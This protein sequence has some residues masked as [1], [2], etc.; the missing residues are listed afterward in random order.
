MSEAGAG[1][2]FDETV[3]K[4]AFFDRIVLSI[5][6]QR[7]IPKKSLVESNI[8][9]G[10]KKRAYARSQK[11]NLPSGNPYELK[12]GRSNWK[13][14]LPSLILTLR[15]EAS[16]LTVIETIAALRSL[17]DDVTRAQI[18]EAELTFDLA[19]ISVDYFRQ[20][21]KS[22]ARIFTQIPSDR[23]T[24]TI[25]VRTRKSPSQLKV[26]KKSPGLTRYEFTL[27]SA[28]L[29]KV[30]IVTPL[31][32]GLVRQLNL[33]ALSSLRELD[34][35]Q[36]E[37]LV[38]R[39]DDLSGR[40]VQSWRRNFVFQEF[41]RV[42]RDILKIPESALLR[43]PILKRLKRMQENLFYDDFFPGTPLRKRK[44]ARS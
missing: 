12:Y 30:G 18:S 2:T 29:R 32:L 44:S 4:R 24:K 36:F 16:P 6:G 14:Y 20:R 26:Y 1:P 22:S 10:G 28:Y 13:G 19:E 5:W 31:D 41:L 37:K 38:A 40:V 7:K 34:E 17:C 42:T 23:E 8:A 11:G 27:R 39:L 9:I 25:Y 43:P 35:V 33:D 21:I 3:N 15:S